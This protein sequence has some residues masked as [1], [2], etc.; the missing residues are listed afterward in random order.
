VIFA[1]YTY[2][3]FLVLTFLLYWC[4]PRALRRP[5][6]IAASYLFYCSWDWRFGFLLLGVSLF[7]WAF[8]RFVLGRG[9]TQYLSLGI[10]VNLSP[11]FVFKYL[12]FFLTNVDVA[13]RAIGLTALPIP[14][15]I[16]P[17]GISFFTFQGIAYLVDVATGDEPFVR[18]EEFVLYK[19][20]WPQ[21]IAGPII[22][23]SE[24]RDQIIEL[25]R[26]HYENVSF[27]CS[28]IVI[29]LVKKVVLADTIGR[30]IDPVFMRNTQPNGIDVLVGAV[31]FGLQVYFDFGGYSD[32]AIGSASLFGFRFPENF[33][34]PYSARSPQEF[35]NR[36]HM[37][38]TRWIR[39]YVF[40]PLAFTL[41]RSNAAMVLSALIAMGLC[42]LWHGARWTFVLWGIWHGLLLI[43]NQTIGKPLFSNLENQKARY[44]FRGLVAWAVTIAAVDLGWILFRCESIGQAWSDTVALLTFRG[45]LR[46]AILRENGVLIVATFFVGLVFVQVIRR[47]HA[48]WFS[49]VVLANR[50]IS[51]LKPAGYVLLVC[52]AIVFDH[53]ATP[54]VYFQF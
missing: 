27:G 38:L 24:I 54:F 32:I 31:G 18:L 40:T 35:W 53:E 47:M 25:P 20:F 12:A 49:D 23:P 26:L 16:L 7:N 36:W 17:L 52:A 28:R 33:D 4:L 37:T 10:I 50:V 1:S 34:F 15:L 5:L 19:S 45:G 9:M 41:R 6:L 44:S 42:G 46:P 39:D 22:R 13:L 51:V 30:L 3:A 8:G 2:I 29:G 11:L 48:A 43:I 21:L 14:S